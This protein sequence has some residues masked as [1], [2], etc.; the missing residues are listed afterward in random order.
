MGGQSLR[1]S[2]AISLISEHSGPEISVLGNTESKFSMEV[3]I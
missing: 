2:E 3:E 1:G